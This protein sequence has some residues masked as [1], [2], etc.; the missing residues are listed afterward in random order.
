MTVP[1]TALG[2]SFCGE[3]REGVLYARLSPDEWICSECWHNAGRPQSKPAPASFEH[4]QEVRRAMLKHN[5]QHRHL[6]NKGLT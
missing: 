3:L 5:G 6:V 1:D 2:C 4:E